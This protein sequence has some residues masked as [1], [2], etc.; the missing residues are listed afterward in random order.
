[1]ITP[2]NFNLAVLARLAAASVMTAGL[3]AGAVA[4]PASA[5]PKETIDYVALGD[6]YSAGLGAGSTNDFPC[7]KTP[8]SFPDRIDARKSVN[9]VANASC[10]GA[11]TAHIPVQAVALTDDTDLVTITVGGND[12]QYST[13]VATCLGFTP[14]DC[15]AS[16]RTA[17]QYAENQLAWDLQT[18][19]AGI[20]QQSDAHVVVMG[21][22]H[23]FSPQFG[24]LGPNTA[25]AKA[26]NE[27][28]TVLNDVIESAADE[29]G[30]QYVD[31][32]KEFRNHGIGA[33]DP[34]IHGVGADAALHPTAEGYKKGYFKTFKSEVQL[35]KIQKKSH[36]YK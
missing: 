27:A 35:N 9:L 36:S 18:V 25:A 2:P 26:M 22:P 23:L 24:R 17:R 20:Q 29:A 13:V 7:L 19:F 12:L 34:W 31:V 16:L 1:M 4:A 6:S 30:F 5:H 8:G 11:I 32:T 14:G 33:P 21:Y 15:T 28:T 10:S 3:V